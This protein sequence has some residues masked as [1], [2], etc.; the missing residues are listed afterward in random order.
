M[1]RNHFDE[2]LTG[3]VEII[4]F[5]E[6]PSP[7]IIPGKEECE[8]CEPTRQLLEEVAA[9]TDKIKL[10]VHELK[11]AT[12]E[13]SSLGIDRIPAFVLRGA[14]RGSVRFFGIPSG[15]E[16]SAFISDLVDVSRGETGLSEETVEFLA[17][18][19]ENVHIKV[20]TTPT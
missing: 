16:F 4:M 7:I 8:M 20:F 17:S 6:L 5:T 2:N 11:N 9:L 10:T 1:I 19:D 15:Y 13:A 14:S 3:D 18:L 12:E